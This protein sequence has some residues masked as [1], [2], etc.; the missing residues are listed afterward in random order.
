MNFAD[1]PTNDLEFR[2]CTNCKNAQ[3][4]VYKPF[5]K[6]VNVQYQRLLMFAIFFIIHV[7]IVY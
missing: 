4:K 5:E 7:F 2:I 1:C 6:C 3:Y